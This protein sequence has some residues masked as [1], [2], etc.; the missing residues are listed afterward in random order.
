MSGR[1][2]EL[3][4][5]YPVHTLENQLLL[6]AGSVL[7]EKALDA[8]I[9]SNKDMPYRE[10][11]LMEHGSVKKDLHEFLNTP[12]YDTIFAHGG[13]ISRIISLMESVRLSMPVLQSLDYFKTNDSYTY[14][15]ILMVFALSSMLTVDM[16]SDYKDR[17]REV[18]SGPIH[19][20]GKICV[21][22]EILKKSTPLTRDEM[23]M[24]KHHTTAGFVLLSYYL[25]DARHLFSA[26]ARDHHER[27]DGSGYP[28][29]ISLKD[30]MVEIVAVSDI[31]D[32]LISPRPY[33]PVAFN[34]RTA[35]EEITTLAEQNKIS[36]DIVK[37]LVAYN[38]KDKPSY[39]ECRV[40]AEKRG[41]PPKDN[42][43][44]IFADE[45]K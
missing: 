4:L 5:E 3:T 42:V 25:K 33:R 36:R 10:Y 15:H 43:Y 9:S 26:V 28:R 21:P 7:S 41:A 2:K 37:A 30:R 40:S 8:L 38:R 35:I 17:I 13:Q 1:H 45:E 6:P 44:G 32:A 19:D 31:Y 18:T 12:P 23:Y 22:F 16:V 24:L 14:R 27:K 39:S 34:N 20:F 11:S 29:G